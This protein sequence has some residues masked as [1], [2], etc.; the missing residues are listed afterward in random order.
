MLWI[1][2]DRSIVNM[3]SYYKVGSTGTYYRSHRTS[4]S[5][6]NSE[7]LF[8]CMHAALISA[9]RSI[10]FITKLMLHFWK[11]SSKLISP[12]L[13]VECS[14]VRPMSNFFPVPLDTALI[15]WQNPM[16]DELGSGSPD[17]YLIRVCEMLTMAD[18]PVSKVRMLY[19][20][21][22]ERWIFY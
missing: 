1:N 2:F 19:N 18:L 11:I 9:F 10:L 16:F 20:R 12:L 5:V 21:N 8:F 3:K 13:C 14:R 7:K 6:W 22:D 15:F 17:C 4:F